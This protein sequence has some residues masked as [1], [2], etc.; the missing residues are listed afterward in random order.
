MNMVILGAASP[1]INMPFESLGNAVRS[2]FRRKGE[3][4]V[5]LNL[6]ALEAGLRFS[7]EPVK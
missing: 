2:L 3:D 1:Y 7:A 6:K 5:S 4:I